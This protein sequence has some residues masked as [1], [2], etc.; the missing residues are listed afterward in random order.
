MI[1]LIM[2]GYMICLILLCLVALFI[3]SPLKKINDN[4]TTAQK[5][6]DHFHSNEHED[7]FN[8]FITFVKKILLNIKLINLGK[9]IMLQ[10]IKQKYKA[11]KEK[12]AIKSLPWYEKKVYSLDRRRK[13][14]EHS[15]LSY[16]YGNRRINDD[17]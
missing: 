14:G 4:R 3:T 2:V 16:D 1:A 6:L 9:I 13:I 7:D 17:N 11:Y 5:I 8:A 15:L 12:Q 10:W